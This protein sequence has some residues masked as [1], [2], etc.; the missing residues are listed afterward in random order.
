[1]CL[2]MSIRLVRCLPWTFIDRGICKE[3]LLKEYKLSLKGEES[4]ISVGEAVTG[5]IMILLKSEVE[6][7]GV[8][9]PRLAANSSY[10]PA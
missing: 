2:D 9:S 10:R 1:M 7:L 6:S 4:D 8:H 5:A 3:H